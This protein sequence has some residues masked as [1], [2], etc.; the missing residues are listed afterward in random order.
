MADDYSAGRGTAGAIEV[1]GSARGRIET[2]GDQDWFAV[3][4]VAGKTYQIDLKGSKGGNGSL[5]D[6]FLRGIYDTN[7]HLVSGTAN[8][9]GGA[10]LNSRTL[11]TPEEGGT[12][13]V[14]AGALVDRTGTYRLSVTNVTDD[15]EAGT[16]TTGT[17]AVGGSARGRIELARDRD[18]FA[19]TLEAGHTYRIDLEGSYTDDGSL[20]DPYLRGVYD[21]DGDLQ[22]GTRNNNGGMY[23]NSRLM[24]TADDAGTYYVAAGANRGRTGTYNLSVT[25]VTDD[26]GAGTGTTGTVEVNGSAT[27]GIAGFG[28]VDWFKV[29]LVAG[30]TYQIDLEGGHTG[31][32]TLDN[33]YL[34]GVYDV[35]GELISGTSIDDGG[36][37]FNS[38]LMFTADASATYY[39]A[40]GASGNGEGTYRLSVTDGA[41]DYPL[42]TETT[43]TVEVDG[44]TTGAIEIAHD[45][46]WFEVTLVAG[47]TYRFDMEGSDTGGGTLSN[48]YIRGVYDE[49]GDYIPA[50]AANENGVGRNA[51]VHFRPEEGGTYYVLAGGHLRETGTYTLSVTEV[52]DDF[53]DGT[54]TSGTVTVGGSATGEIE[55]LT[56]KDWFA[57]TLQAGTTY[58]IDLEGSR[59]GDGTLRDPYLGGVHDSDG[60]L[61]DGTTHSGGSGRNSRVTFTAAENG[62]Y[63]VS[64]E[65]SLGSEGTYTLS[66]EEVM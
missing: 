29:T 3:T 32:G 37:G 65:A 57:L 38:R 66:V 13:Y 30:T 55:Y 19:V 44:S 51:Q 27:G 49:D 14:A 36:R 50:T 64:A 59:T 8:D 20:V 52:Q 11:F 42:T 47:K 56:D 33:P 1:G 10:G 17:V 46:D 9:D 34:R 24:F 58:R 61:I 5:Y 4:L 43:G 53:T 31:A 12:Y 22:S 35:D 7:G 63:Y 16:G 23:T 6:P 62:T 28:D 25:D 41:D 45:I 15:F 26:F 2:S 54:G 40:A 60:V 18:W 48:P 21:E 39:V